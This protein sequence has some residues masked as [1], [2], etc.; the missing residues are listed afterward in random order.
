M[1]ALHKEKE[2]QGSKKRF[3]V[4]VIGYICYKSPIFFIQIDIIF[5]L[6]VND[7]FPVKTGILVFLTYILKFST[8][9]S[10]VD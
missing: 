9:F 8:V 3:T 4:R 1:E 10:H 6:N 7:I 2:A 5:L